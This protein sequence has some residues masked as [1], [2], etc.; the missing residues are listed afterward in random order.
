MGLVEIS[1]Q[2][3]PIKDHMLKSPFSEKD[4]VYYRYTVEEL[5]YAGKHRQW[6][7]I[8]KGERRE[9]FYV[10]DE[11]GMVLVDSNGASI[12]VARDNE[13]SSGLG[14]DPPETVKHFLSTNNFS[15]ENFLGMNKTMRYRES[16]IAPNDSLYILGTADD[17]PFVEDAKAPQGAED[18]IIKKGNQEKIYYISDKQE[19]DILRGLAWKV[20]GSIIGGAAFIVIGIIGIVW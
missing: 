18:V 6:V 4:C 19:R 12:E 1:G 14:C 17:N 7:T 2:V 10:Q 9:L 5:R 3:I 8:N 11:T 13:F 20:A 15:F 16:Y